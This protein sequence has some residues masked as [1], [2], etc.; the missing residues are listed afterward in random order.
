M[1]SR[2]LEKDRAV[3]WRE[4]ERYNFDT[5]NCKYEGEINYGEIKNRMRQNIEV[6]MEISVFGGNA[7]FPR[8]NY[9]EIKNRTRQNIERQNTERDR[10]WRD[11]IQ[12]ETE[13]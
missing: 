11:E 4:E 6:N 10:I 3:N 7:R 1:S 5:L 12:R 2:K 8:I 13:W 9:G